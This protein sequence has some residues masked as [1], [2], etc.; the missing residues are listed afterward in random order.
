MILNFKPQFKGLILNG[1]KIHSI[2]IDQHRKW[3]PGMVIHYSTG[4]RTKLY[5]QFWYGHCKSIQEINIFRRYDQGDQIFL[6]V[7]IDH[8]KFSDLELQEFIKN[9]GLD[10]LFEFANWFT[11]EPKWIFSGRLIHWTSKRY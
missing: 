1:T 8:R 3:K 2:R 9:D 4:A 6:G 10:D 11:P 7:Y 5:N